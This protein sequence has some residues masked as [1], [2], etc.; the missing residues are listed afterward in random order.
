[1]SSGMRLPAVQAL[2]AFAGGPTA[3]TD[4]LLDQAALLHVARRGLE[5]AGTLHPDGGAG[6]DCSITHFDGRSRHGWGGLCEVGVGQGVPCPCN[7]SRSLAQYLPR[8]LT[9][10]VHKAGGKLHHTLRRKAESR[11]HEHTQRKYPRSG[12]SRKRAVL[13]ETNGEHAHGEHDPSQ[14]GP[15]QWVARSSVPCSLAAGPRS[16]VAVYKDRLLKQLRRTL[17]RAAHVIKSGSCPSL[18]HHHV[19]QP[20]KDR[21]PTADLG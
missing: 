12:A 2:L 16:V 9:T 7:A 3:G 1:M 21:I 15:V 6:F 20:L 14:S 8:Y 4:N 10:A 5:H 17:R 19:K 13:K 18:P 11:M